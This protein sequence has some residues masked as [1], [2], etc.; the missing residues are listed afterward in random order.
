M[1]YKALNNLVRS[2]LLGGVAF[3]SLPHT[4]GQAEFRSF[5]AFEALNNARLYMLSSRADEKDANERLPKA[6]DA[7]AQALVRHGKAVAAYRSLSDAQEQRQILLADEARLQKEWRQEEQAID[8]ALTVA[9]A[10]L[11]TARA[12]LSLA[13]NAGQNTDKLSVAVADRSRAVR[14]LYARKSGLND[15]RAITQRE[16]D[17]Q[18]KPLNEIMKT[19]G[20]VS[21]V[22][23]LFDLG[24]DV[25]QKAEAL[26][27]AHARAQRNAV[28]AR[29]YL[30][31]YYTMLE[32][33]RPPYIK[34][35]RIKHG[36]T[37]LYEASW[38]ERPGT[39]KS[40]PLET[41]A[42]KALI[43]KDEQILKLSRQRIEALTRNRKELRKIANNSRDYAQSLQSQIAG[44]QNRALLQKTA[45][46]IAVVAADLAISGGALTIAGFSAGKSAE[47]AISAYSRETARAVLRETGVSSELIG[48]VAKLYSTMAEKAA[49]QK[50]EA[51][52]ANPTSFEGDAL[53]AASEVGE[54]LFEAATSKGIETVFDALGKESAESAAR[55]TAFS[56]VSKAVSGSGAI[57]DA[58]KTA[59][60]AKGIASAA[61]LIADISAKIIIAR[62]EQEALE[63]LG[64]DKLKAQAN[65]H[66]AQGAWNRVHEELLAEQRRALFYETRIKALETRIE[67][68]LPSREL[69][70]KTNTSLDEKAIRTKH[71]VDV[72]FEVSQPLE[73]APRL[74][75]STPGGVTIE[76]VTRDTRA[77]SS[78]WK[79]VMTLDED[80]IRGID[81]I[82]LEFRLLRGT[83]RPYWD[84][85][86]NPATAPFLKDLDE[87]TWENFE[88]GPDKNH[89][90][91]IRPYAPDMVCAPSEGTRQT[92]ETDTITAGIVNTEENPDCTY[93]YDPVFGVLAMYPSDD[94]INLEWIRPIRFSDEHDLNQSGGG[95]GDTYPS[96]R[97]LDFIPGPFATLTRIKEARPEEDTLTEF[98]LWGSTGGVY[99]GSASVTLT[100]TCGS[101]SKDNRIGRVIYKTVST[102]IVA[103]LK[104]NGIPIPGGLN[105]PELR[106]LLDDKNA[107]PKEHVATV[108]SG[109]GK[110]KVYGI[111][112]CGNQ[113]ADFY[114]ARGIQVHATPLQSEDRPTSLSASQLAA[115]GHARDR[116]SQQQAE[117][118]TKTLEAGNVVAALRFARNRM[119]GLLAFTYR[120]FLF[121]EQALKALPDEVNDWQV[122]AG[123]AN[124][125]KVLKSQIEST[126]AQKKQLNTQ[127][128][129]LGD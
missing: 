52:I 114:S 48:S 60:S 20:A 10:R 46:D 117:Q 7:Y 116:K 8:R 95:Y 127:L 68:G 66:I 119:D 36:K 112:R 93:W 86:T 21:G 5:E 17:E 94:S 100:Y 42:L 75:T 101:D 49:E 71:V 12:E 55:K 115:F 27:Q 80:Q 47:L 24:F 9:Q 32:G 23:A 62:A 108:T 58:S 109:Q 84:F 15:V 104:T 67:F 120:K 97:R 69:V 53:V 72:F 50:I 57:F 85:D 40:G 92:A 56:S 30:V 88:P 16:I 123:M 35:V 41:K 118:Q 2:T 31:T 61:S 70:V 1:S 125:Q 111:K 51:L 34:S 77:G 128:K 33:L 14:D 45:V 103:T 43:V 87:R 6:R 106:V 39:E 81:A 76:K 65:V 90:L 38:E 59:Q 18:L 83:H 54:T 107:F 122:G 121:H 28:Q 22:T 78:H 79:T 110:T 63:R 105:E 102:P 99:I 44:A 13:K 98:E 74:T 82:P 4:A 11:E 3:L 64:N 129:L 25:R 124:T 126:K 19:A 89:T 96:L 37:V 26:E 91:Q 113:R 29:N 73:E